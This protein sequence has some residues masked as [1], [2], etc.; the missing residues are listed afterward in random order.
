MPSALLRRSQPVQA[1]PPEAWPR[2]IVVA[3]DGRAPSDVALIAARK[4]APRSTFGVLSIL[5]AP[6]SNERAVFPDD[7]LTAD[8]HMA[9]I[10]RQLQRLF[11]EALDVWVETEAGD[12]PAVIASYAKSRGTPLVITGIGRPRVRDRLLGDESALRLMR[13]TDT[14]ILA[15]AP[16]C[17]VPA[18][19][20]II[21]MD[22][23]PSS[24]GAARLA[25]AIAS[26]QAELFVIHVCAATAA[27]AP[28]GRLHRVAQ[29]LQTG[30]CGRVT[31]RM[32]RGDPGTELL[33]FANDCS[34]DAIA[35]GL[36]R[37]ARA[38]RIGIGAVATRIVRCA[39]CSVVAAPCDVSGH[40]VQI[41]YAP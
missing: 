28:E 8:E 14:P 4:L 15:V 25:L 35:I 38:E 3:S 23:T 13:L 1:S 9:I 29:A 32:L 33:A 31:A 18:R 37:H 5:P 36:H 10:E 2:G 16:G 19:R 20:V 22:F 12:P 30:F 41:P 24:M 11:G 21:A 40:Q 7:V 17:E 34:A 26:P 39:P 6:S 27:A